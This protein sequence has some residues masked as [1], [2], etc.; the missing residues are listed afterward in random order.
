MSNS[1]LNK[2][3]E[4]VQAEIDQI[5]AAAQAKVT[6]YQAETK[7]LLELAAAAHHEALQKEIA[8]QE[9]VA[10]SKARQAGN[11]ATQSAKRAGIDAVFTAAM[12]D[13][14]EADAAAYVS[15]F[16]KV[17]KE[18][19]PKNA[20]GTAYAPKDRLDETK[21]ILAAIGADATV[22]AR[23]TVIGGLILDTEDG[24]YD[25]SVERIFMELRP[26]LEVE[27]LSRVQ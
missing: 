14:V 15:F 23:N 25:A 8:H 26:T 7:R 10:V 6:D 3:N 19:V 24:V 9:T 1:L 27:L 21:Q 20:K 4:D 22:E 16:T 18:V 11:I 2:I 13:V 12:K 17:A 5:E